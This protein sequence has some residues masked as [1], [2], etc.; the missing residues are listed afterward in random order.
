[1]LSPGNIPVAALEVGPQGMVLK[2]LSALVFGMR[3]RYIAR[4]QKFRGYCRGSR[5]WLVLQSFL[6]NPHNSQ[7]YCNA[8]ANHYLPW[9]A[10]TVGTM[11]DFL[12]P[13][14]QS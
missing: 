12:A 4:W 11:C 2:L 14:K 3:H 8:S 6:G 13:L 5:H 7:W 9:S 10:V 1:M